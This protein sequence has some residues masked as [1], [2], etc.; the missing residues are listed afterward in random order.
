MLCCLLAGA[1]S[2]SAEC[3]WVLWSQPYAGTR[4]EEWVLQTAYASISECTKAIDD[5]EAKTPKNTYN[6]ERRARTDLF[7]MEK[8][9]A[10][11]ATWQC[12]PDTVDPR[13]PTV[14]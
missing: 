14:K 3:A 1:T 2:A 8:T 13:G 9:W 12:L 4:A 5:R 7:V 11:G 10:R 6:I